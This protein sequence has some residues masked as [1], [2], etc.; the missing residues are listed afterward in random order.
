MIKVQHNIMTLAMQK[1]MQGTTFK[2]N[3]IKL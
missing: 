2:W 1:S 3:M